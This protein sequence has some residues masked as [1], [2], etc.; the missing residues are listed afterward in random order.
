VNLR[1]QQTLDAAVREIDA[2]ADYHRAR[3]ALEAAT[4]ARATA[5]RR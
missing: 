2:L 3:A 4:A 1:E 5:P